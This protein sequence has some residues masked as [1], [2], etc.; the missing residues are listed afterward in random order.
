MTFMAACGTAGEPRGGVANV[1]VEPTS[2]LVDAGGLAEGAREGDEASPEIRCPRPEACASL[3]GF[4]QR[5][6]TKPRHG[7]KGNLHVLVVAGARPEETARGRGFLDVVARQLITG[8]D[9]SAEGAQVPYRVDGIPPRGRDYRVFAFLDDDATSLERS[10]RPDEG[11]LCA[12]TPDA[13]G[14]GDWGM[15]VGLASAGEVRL[16][17][18]LTS[19]W[20]GL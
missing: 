13:S 18:P 20:T 3:V 1:P 5:T 14:A 9:L 10:P 11:D 8:V 6:A 4:V 2:A 12:A 7:G 15:G 16:D 17:I 19:V